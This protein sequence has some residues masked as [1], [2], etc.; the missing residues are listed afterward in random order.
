MTRWVPLAAGV[1]AAV[2]AIVLI[3]A[4][5]LSGVQPWGQL[6]TDNFV[7]A[8]S[9]PF[10]LG[11]GVAFGAYRAMGRRPPSVER[12]AGDGAL[13]RFARGTA[14]MHWV[15]SVG[16]LLALVTGAW[17]YLK[18]L[19]AVESRIDM[20]LVYRVHYVGATLLLFGVAHFVT[21][22][23]MDTRH[24][25]SVP[26]GQWIRHLRGMAHELPR[27]LGSALAA[28]LGLDMRRQAPPAGEFTYYEKVFSF[29]TWVILIGLIVITGILKALRYI[30]PIPGDLLWWVSAIHVGAM[31]GLAVKLLDHVRYVLAPSRWPLLVASYTT[32]ISRGYAARAH[33]AWLETAEEPAAEQPSGAPAAQPVASQG[34]P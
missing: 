33:P 1:L 13:R 22:W 14:V 21:Y 18:G 6:L 3:A 11:L 2:V 24:P 15:I 12:R 31:V 8:R 9:I 17:Q 28:M 25:L 27:P 7:F 26:S 10:T 19:L 20:P 23:L 29:P 5:V 4:Q 32:W 16:F 34:T 30:Y